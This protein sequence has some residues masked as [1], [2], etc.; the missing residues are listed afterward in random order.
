MATLEEL[1]AEAA[2]L[3]VEQQELRSRRKAVNEEI[4][5]LEN[6]PSTGGGSIIAPDGIASEESV[7]GV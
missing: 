3:E 5:A 6:Q 4:T 7:R 2:A 1:Y